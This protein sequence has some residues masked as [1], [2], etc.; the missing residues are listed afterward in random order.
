MILKHNQKGFTLIELL[1]TVAILGIITGMSIPVIRNIQLRN[2]DRKF[3]IYGDSLITAA[4]IYRD[5]YEEDLFGRRQTGCAEV[6]FSKLKEKNLIKDFN[7]KNISCD[8]AETVVK[9]VKLKKQYGYSYYLACGTKNPDGTMTIKYRKSSLSKK[10]AKVDASKDEATGLDLCTPSGAINLNINVERSL[11]GNPL[12]LTSSSI[13]KV[14]IDSSTGINP[15]SK[16]QYA[17]STNDN[18]SLAELVWNEVSLKKPTESEQMTIMN[19]GANVE[20]VSGKLNKPDSGIYYLY[21]KADQI[22]NLDGEPWVPSEDTP[23]YGKYG[24]YTMN[25]TYTL[26]YNLTDGS[27]TCSPK[28]VYQNLE[29]TEKWG[30]LCASHTKIGHTFKEWNTSQDG[31]GTVI[32]NDTL[33]SQDLTVYAIW[34]PNTCT[35]TFDENGGVFGGTTNK[36]Q[37]MLYGRSTTNTFWNANGGSF[38]ATKTGY[39][40]D[41]ATAWIRTSDNQTIDETA[42]YAATD[43]C[44]ALAD[45]DQAVTLKVNWKPNQYTVSYKA[46][47]GSGT[48]NNSKCTYGQAVTPSTNTFTKAHYTFNGWTGKPAT[49]TGNVELTATWR[50]NI[51]KIEY[52]TNSKNAV[53]L[54]SR[55]NFKKS[56]DYA[57]VN[58]SGSKTLQKFTYG[59]SATDE[60]KNLYNYH[61]TDWLYIKRTA[62]NAGTA[63]DGAEFARVG[64]SCK[65]ATYDHDVDYTTDEYCDT[66][67]GDCTCIVKVNWQ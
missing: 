2:E 14:R 11:N 13:I 20:A 9:I 27:G 41:A 34:K 67:N 53:I 17:W 56:G 48:M 47:G 39:H 52:Q 51:A 62:T 25:K 6:S 12:N 15:A 50:A 7:D 46:G 24:P 66:T 30:N 1:V 23:G 40:A 32:T 60:Q 21:I 54:E 16:I 19:T 37:T 65:K 4:K 59:V 8:S 18:A 49:C 31:T 61:N 64:T 10:Q 28:E 35:I 36:V 22:S 63:K 26:T 45:G 44:P 42:N 3:K 38:K 33:A 29:G 5:S 55:A 43:I 57:I 58:S